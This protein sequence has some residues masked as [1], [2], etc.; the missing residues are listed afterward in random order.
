MVAI[1]QAARLLFALRVQDVGRPLKDLEVS[2][3]PTELRRSLDAAFAEG[4]ALTLGAVSES[5]G[6]K[7]HLLEVRLVPLRET[8]EVE[9]VSVIF[10]DIEKWLADK[11]KYEGE[12]AG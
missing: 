7:D 11:T 4:R 1:N 8:G 6:G 3:R 5:R 10:A 9:A 2:Y 12:K